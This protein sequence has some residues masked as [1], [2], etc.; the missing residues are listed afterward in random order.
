[1]QPCLE[2][3][4][5][6]FGRIF[7]GGEELRTLAGVA[8]WALPRV[9]RHPQ[10]RLAP[11]SFGAARRLGGGGALRLACVCRCRP[12]RKLVVLAPIPVL[13]AVHVN[14]WGK[15][16]LRPAIPPLDGFDVDAEK[17]SDHAVGVVA[18]RHVL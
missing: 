15:S 1:M 12:A 6:P 7:G 4:C 14:R 9:L 16:K 5:A 13:A 2:T 10:T 11:P 3:A 17:F 18:L 8:S